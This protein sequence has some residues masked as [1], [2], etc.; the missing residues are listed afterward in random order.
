MPWHPP[1][2]GQPSVSPKQQAIRPSTIHR[3]L[4]ILRPGFQTQRR[5]PARCEFLVV[6]E[7]SML[8]L[9][10]TNHL[11]K[12][13]RP[14][15]HV[16]FVGDVDQ[17]PSVGAGDVLR[18]I[19]ASGMAPVTRLTTIFRQAANSQII[20]NAHLINQGKMPIFSK[21]GGDF[22]LFPAED[23]AAAADWVVKVVAER[24]PQKFGFDACAISRCWLPS[25]AARPGS[26]RSTSACRKSSIRRAQ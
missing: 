2:G 25:I 5:E 26:V 3:L 19:I 13:V 18:N 20:T 23:A 8:D 9:L 16:L 22:F 7:A 14:G 12:A 15:T 17:L 4:E 6:D 1:P 10:L 24:I 11:L 21:E